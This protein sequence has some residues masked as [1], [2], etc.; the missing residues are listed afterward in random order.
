[1]KQ[2]SAQ[3]KKQS[4]SIRMRASEKR[5]LHERVVSY[6][7]YHPLPK[8]MRTGTQKRTAPEIYSEHF[9]TI[10]FNK[11]YARNFGGIFAMLCILA[12][13]V[14]AERSL[15]GDV[16]Y[17]VKVDFTEEL[18]A[19]LSFSPYAKV[20]W[21]TERL[22]RRI[23]EARLLANE[24]KLTQEAQTQ[25]AAAIKTHADAAQ[26]EIATLRE[27][28]TDEAA[29]AEI[30]FA[31]AL[32]VQSE[33]LEEHILNE[34]QDTAESGNTILAVAEMV[35]QARNSAE[36]AQSDTPASYEGLLA[37]VELESTRVYE[38]FASVKSGASEEEVKD[39]ERRLAD[40]ERKMVNAIALKEGTPLQDEADVAQVVALMSQEALVESTEISLLSTTT[41]EEI[42]ETEVPIPNAIH[43]SE[44][45]PEIDPAITQIEATELLRLTLTDIQKLINYLTNIDVRENVSIEALVPVTLTAQERALK[46]KSLFDETQ[47]LLTEVEARQ[48]SSR[49]KGKVN[50]G[51]DDVAAKL[52]SVTTLMEKGSLDEARSRVEDAH[53][54]ALDLLQLVANEPLK[55]SGDE[56][57]V[58]EE[59]PTTEVVTPEEEVPEEATPVQ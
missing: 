27:S 25:F 49:L 53:L 37:A 22:E 18:R 16:L 58:E 46:I 43:V 14:F 9:F 29:I 15:P 2:F 47:K 38:L 44:T 36:T 59:A 17:P 40:I 28:D 23:S 6:M 42:P 32:A 20:A 33:V 21:E 13:P 55:V 4:E 1:M 57:T 52:E 26:R 51:Q 7:E 30:A 45:I 19:T 8:E 5:A 11:G 34:T 48:I 31:S 54:G 35:A 39:V 24:G 56:I 12:V 10:P 3:F 50:R 41:P